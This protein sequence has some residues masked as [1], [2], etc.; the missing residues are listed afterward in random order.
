MSWR[1]WLLVAAAVLAI[2]VAIALAAAA[3]DVLRVSDA[4]AKD[5]I[6]FQA[7]PTVQSGLWES[8][9]FLPG[10]VA[11]RAVGL[12]DDL[13]YRQA[14][15]LFAR[16][17]PGKVYVS[18]PEG[19]ALRASAES[20]L[21][22]ASR[23]E[24]NGR[25]RAQLL[26]MLGLL[27]LDR[28]AE[29]PTDRINIVRS[30]IGSFQAAIKTDPDNADAKFNLELVLRNFAAEQAPGSQPDRGPNRGRLSGLGRSGSG[31]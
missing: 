10:G 28:Y 29:D 23:A 31:Y 15:W 12:E 30:A 20:K 17:Q 21:V 8:K 19:D 7:R 14:V 18:T 22:D 11:R 24:A 4:V 2:P 1:R 9:G 25:R 6:R 27:A 3:V 5:D 26:N 13:R 16:V